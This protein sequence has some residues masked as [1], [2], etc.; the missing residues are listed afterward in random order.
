[1]P[2]FHCPRSVII[3]LIVWSVFSPIFGSCGSN[4][5]PLWVW[6]PGCTNWAPVSVGKGFRPHCIITCG[7]SKYIA[8]STT[9][10]FSILL[11]S[12]Y[13]RNVIFWVGLNPNQGAS[14]S[15][16]RWPI[17]TTQTLWKSSIWLRP[18]INTSSRR[19]ICWNA[20]FNGDQNTLASS[21][22][23]VSSLKGW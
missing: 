8:V 18:D 17:E 21:L 1:M 7:I 11:N 3:A 19:W 5:K 22:A 15:P 9:L 14:N 20:V 12:Q 2:R 10:L 6:G 23:D 13:L 4:N 16:I